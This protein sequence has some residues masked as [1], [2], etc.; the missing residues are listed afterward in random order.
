MFATYNLTIFV[1]FTAQR[2]DC[3]ERKVD[4]E[5]VD[6]QL[7]AIFQGQ[8]IRVNVNKSLLLYTE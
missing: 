6:G 5:R 1:D 4:W 8:H 3:K 2:M 7:P